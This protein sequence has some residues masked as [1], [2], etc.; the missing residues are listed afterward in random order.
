[1]GSRIHHIF[2]AE[3]GNED[4]RELGHQEKGRGPCR[5]GEA[6]NAIDRLS[7]KLY[8]SVS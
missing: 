7:G 6:L 1:M 4:N 2:I 8:S 5:G 3:L